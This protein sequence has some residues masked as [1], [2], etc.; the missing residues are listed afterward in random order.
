I[1][2]E[3]RL[4][5]KGERNSRLAE[6]PA[7]PTDRIDQLLRSRRER[8]WMECEPQSLREHELLHEMVINREQ[9]EFRPGTFDFSIDP[10]IL[11]F[12][13]DL[14]AAIVEIALTRPEQMPDT[15]LDALTDCR[16]ANAE[17]IRAKWRAL[18][19]RV[20]IGAWNELGPNAKKYHLSRLRKFARRLIELQPELGER[21]SRLNPKNAE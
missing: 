11:D 14:V 19:T 17:Q 7:N 18:E 21:Q 9:V 15:L 1:E 12:R 5:D 2:A 16:G 6:P 20:E 4:R 8:P 13:P 3:R 10:M